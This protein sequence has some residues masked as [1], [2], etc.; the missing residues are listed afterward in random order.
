MS[1]DAVVWCVAFSPDG[2]TLGSAGDDRII[3]LW[4]AA[5]GRLRATL[6]GHADVVWQ[7]TW[8]PEG[9]LL[10]STSK[11]TTIRLW[12]PGT[13]KVKATLPGHVEWQSA[14]AFSP[15]GKTLAEGCPERT[16]RLWDVQTAK[17]RA[18]LRWRKDWLAEQVAPLPK[19][20]VAVAFSPD[21][22]TL[23]SG[24]VD[25][26]ISLWDVVTRKRRA[27]LEDHIGRMTCL[28]YSPDGKLLASAGGPVQLWDARTGKR[29]AVLEGRPLL[30]GCVAFSPD[31]KT[32]AVEGQGKTIAL[33][34][35]EKGKEHATL[36]EQTDWVTSVAFSPDGKTL[37]A[38]SRH[39]LAANRWLGTIH[40]W[41]V[42]TG[43]ERGG[44]AVPL[45]V[46]V[47]IKAGTEGLARGAKIKDIR[48]EKATAGKKGLREVSEQG[49]G[50]AVKRLDGTY[51]V[52]KAKVTLADGKV[53]SC[54][55]L[56][57]VDPGGEALRDVRF[58]STLEAKADEGVG[59]WHGY[60]AVFDQR[61]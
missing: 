34:D 14:V 56:V 27:T 22:K 12:D 44:K 36:T 57:S 19:Q 37:A 24:N 5:T 35:V 43:K 9:K 21:R 58:V 54:E 25:R 53:V 47:L 28:A 49:S 15:D 40:L 18:T 29:Q 1:H 61:E 60:T 6:K 2:K 30:T 51:A 33:W 20:E 26:T 4:D 8:S 16:V 41:D 7:V 39:Y 10:A 32:L 11:D 48:P 52:K 45:K 31:G 55:L 59:R 38:A 17:V 42:A 23:A 46:V 3:K 13:G 50:K